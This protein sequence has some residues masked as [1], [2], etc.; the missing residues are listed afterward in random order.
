MGKYGVATGQT[1]EAS[2]TAC[3]PNSNS[4]SQSSVE[5]D[6]TSN[7]DYAGYAG[8]GTCRLRLVLVLGLVVCVYLQYHRRR[9]PK[10][11]DDINVSDSV[12]HKQDFV[13]SVQFP[14]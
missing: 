1:A 4:P 6:C 2:C 13:I 3:T 7:A 14:L 10:I 11:A 12:G 8:V 5:T 9:T